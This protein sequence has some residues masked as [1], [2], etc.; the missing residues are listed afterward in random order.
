MFDK[1]LFSS[2][3]KEYG[4]EFSRTATEPIFKD[5]KDFTYEELELLE[6]CLSKYFYD[7]EGTPEIVVS[8]YNKIQKKKKETE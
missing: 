7:V 3:C 8:C 1:D 5:D 6:R 4:V 2:I